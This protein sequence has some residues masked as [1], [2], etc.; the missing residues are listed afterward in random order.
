MPL[1]GELS[2]SDRDSAGEQ[3]EWGIIVSCTIIPL[4]SSFYFVVVPHCLI[5]YQCSSPDL[6]G[7]GGGQH[8]EGSHAPTYPFPRAVHRLI[9]CL[10]RGCLAGTR[11]HSGRDRGCRW[12]SYACLRHN[13]P[14]SGPRDDTRA[15]CLVGRCTA[16]GRYFG[17]MVDPCERSN[18]FVYNAR[19]FEGALWPHAI[20][21][22][23]L[24]VSHSRILDRC[25]FDLGRFTVASPNTRL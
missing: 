2:F 10:A 14:R 19:C 17:R 12:A 6:F 16:G 20:W 7:K 18:A 9:H 11:K 22:A 23:L 24:S 21:R 5:R 15:Q 8:S 13:Q 25:L 4:I 3:D 1:G